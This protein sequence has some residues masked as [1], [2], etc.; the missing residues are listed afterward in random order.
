MAK[1]SGELRNFYSVVV[2]RVLGRGSGI[3][4]RSHILEEK[5][6]REGGG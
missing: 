2:R 3:L 5:M 6:V 1:E 4:G